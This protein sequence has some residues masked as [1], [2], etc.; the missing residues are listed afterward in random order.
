MS[1]DRPL[2]GSRLDSRSTLTMILLTIPSDSG[3]LLMPPLRLSPMAAL[4]TSTFPSSSLA[5][6]RSSR[7][8]VAQ[9]RLE[10]LTWPKSTPS[11][12]PLPWL[13]LQLL[14]LAKLGPSRT[15]KRRPESLF[16]SNLEP[17]LSGTRRWSLP[18]LQTLSFLASPCVS[19]K[20][21][22][23]PTLTSSETT[24]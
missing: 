19:S 17:R 22:S 16:L 13:P 4:F 24:R 8:S 1:L 3:G 11:T 12:A 20:E 6:P 2:S 23:P 9:L 5:P 21:S 14:L 18:P 10:T 7:L 15:L